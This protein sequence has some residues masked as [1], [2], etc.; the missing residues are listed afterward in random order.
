M[1]R[2]KDG[3]ILRLIGKWLQAGVHEAGTL[4]YPDQGTPQ[5]GV[6]SPMVAHVCLHQVLDAWCGQAVQPSPFNMVTVVQ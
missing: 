4:T 6:A 5:G 3:G 1:Q 2:V